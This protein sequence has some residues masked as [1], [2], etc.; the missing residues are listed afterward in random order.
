VVFWSGRSVRG[1]ELAP[2]SPAGVTGPP[3]RV[4]P[5]PLSLLAQGFSATVAC[6]GSQQ[7]QVQA[8][9]ATESP[10]TASRN[11]FPDPGVFGR[12]LPAVGPSRLRYRL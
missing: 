7:T 4:Y 5:G 9:K 6:S 1:I 2:W 12:S 11:K 3:C 10:V 8:V